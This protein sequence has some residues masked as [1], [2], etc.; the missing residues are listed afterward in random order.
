MK[1]MFLTSLALALAITTGQAQSSPSSDKEAVR[2]AAMNYLDAL[3]QAKPE[4]IEKSV[5]PDLSK[6]G[7]FHK[8]GETALQQRADVLPA[9]LRP[10]REVEQ[11][12]QAPAREGAEGGRRLRGPE[13][14]RQRK[15][16]RLLGHRLH[17]PRQVRRHLEDREHPLAG[18]AT[19]IAAVTS[20]AR[21]ASIRAPS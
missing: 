20:G 8:K 19:Q 14:D 17:A 4:L 3:Y 9:A 5:H 21:P 10:C 6:R 12:R 2:Q 15:G 16:H 18:A 11:G 7:Y 13:P 1:Q